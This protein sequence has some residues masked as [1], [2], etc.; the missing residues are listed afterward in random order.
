MDW[1]VVAVNIAYLF[2][3][4]IKSISDIRVLICTVIVFKMPQKF[5]T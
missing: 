2:L 3:S 5:K 4:I 1:F